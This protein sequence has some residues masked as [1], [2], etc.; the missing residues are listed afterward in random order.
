MPDPEKQKRKLE[1]IFRE[2]LF[3][4][5]FEFHPDY[6]IGAFAGLSPYISYTYVMDNRLIIRGRPMGECFAFDSQERVI[7]AS[8]ESLE[9]LISV[10]WR[11]CDYENEL[12][13]NLNI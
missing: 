10:G 9:E 8:Y 2:E 12:S 6:C 3:A 1:A 7:I 4:P 11:L 5:A 13:I